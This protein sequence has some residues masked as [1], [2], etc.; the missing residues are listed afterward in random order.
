MLS[1][2]EIAQQAKLRPITE[3]AAK[4]SLSEDDIE[5]Y[6]KY[7]AKVSNAVYDRLKDKPSGKLIYTTAITATPAGEGK[8]VTTIGLTQALGRLGKNVAACI[9]E[10]SLG[11]TFGIKGGAAGGGYSQVVPM[12]DI[13]L[14]FTGDIHAVTTAHNLLAAM[15]DNHIAQGNALNIDPK[16]IVLRRVLD[17]NDRQLRN[18]VIGLG[19]LGDGYVREAGFDISVASEIMAILC[20]ASDLQ[21]LK[22]RVG[23]MLVAYTYDRKPVYA[24]DLK[25]EGAIAVIM[26][27]AIKP[28]LVQTLE[29]QPVF[30]H[31]GPFANIA[32][33]NNSIIATRLALKLADYVVTEGGFASDLGAEKFF[34]IVHGYSGLKPDVAVLVVSVRA[35]NMHGGVPKEEVQVTNLEALRKGLANLD[36][37]VENLKKFGL[38][39]V[40]AINQ[41]PTDTPEELELVRQ[42]CAELGVRSAISQVVAK[43]GAGGEELAK[44]V[45]EVLESEPAQFEPL[46]DWKL[47][48]K[49]K[50]EILAKEIYGADDVVYTPKAERSIRDLTKLG[51]GELPVCVAK[52]QHSISDNPKLK[53]VPKGWKLTITDVRP[54]LGAGFLVCLAG[55]IMTM[56]GLPAKPA[57]E[58]V[59]ID[60][61]GRIT[62]LF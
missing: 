19:G 23:R 18:I 59:D 43:G 38:P 46:Y 47:P 51:Y 52:T 50:L 41:F 33:G 26:K 42:H 8:T 31:G 39:I 1:D 55:D 24:R 15:L 53:G 13:N 14:H 57:A 3:I 20:L 11:P 40:V 49:S 27:D 10:P 21:D 62:G 22:E 48:I 9:R 29:G 56:P 44:T 7:K 54:S 25:A 5:L 60:A 16:R 34:D 4:L 30:I 35:L 58:N 28:N 45:L 2:I 36:K 32:H 37:H 17:I 12:E 6:G 61:E